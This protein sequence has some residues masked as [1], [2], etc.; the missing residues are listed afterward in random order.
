MTPRPAATPT[1]LRLRALD[2]PAPGPRL[3]DVLASYWPAYR[4][5]IARAEPVAPGAATDALARHMPELVPVFDRLVA[6]GPPR[7]RERL[8]RFFSLYR[9]PR[10]VRGC[11]Q[12]IVRSED[13]PRLIRN[14]DHAPHL[15]DGL[16]LRSAWLGHPVV[17]VTDCLWGALDGVNAHGLCVALAFGGRPDT[18]DGFG[19]QLVVRYL[20]E[21]CRTTDDARAALA[22]LPV[23]MPYTFVTLDAAGASVTAFLGPGRAARFVDDPAST[24]HQGAVEW[25]AYAAHCRTVERLDHLHALLNDDRP[26]PDTVEGAFLEPPLYQTDYARAAGTLYTAIFRPGP[27]SLTLRWPADRAEF[28]IDRFAESDRTVL[29]GPRTAGRR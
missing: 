28:A 23:S 2:E 3:A 10:V 7:D 24:N 29:I 8:V 15:F 11:S 4:R 14:Y 6:M 26:D 21:T 1:R 19:A 17:A 18:G 16:V 5:W 9:P 27:R 13:G 22:R 12:A 25:P 20:L